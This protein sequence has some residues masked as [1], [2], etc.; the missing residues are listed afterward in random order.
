MVPMTAHCLDRKMVPSWV[1]YLVPMTD[2][3]LH[4]KVPLMELNSDC[5]TLPHLDYPMVIRKDLQMELNSDC[6]TVS[7]WDLKMVPRTVHYLVQL[8]LTAHCL[9]HCLVRKM[10]PRTGHYLVHQQ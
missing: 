8:T 10:A 4:P 9:V 2:H 5:S 1:H 7:H 6:L 3:R